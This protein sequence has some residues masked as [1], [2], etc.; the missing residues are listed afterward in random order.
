MSGPGGTGTPALVSAALAPVYAQPELPAALISQLVLGGRVDVLE[1]RGC[2][3]TVRS[4]D[5][6][7]G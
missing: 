3:V 5:G 6:Y 2:W 1:H 4:E 7:L